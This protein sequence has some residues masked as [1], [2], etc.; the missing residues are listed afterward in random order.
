MATVLLK[1]GKESRVASGYLWI[2]S[3]EI[4]RADGHFEDGGIVDVRTLRGKWLGRGFINSQSGLA[5]RL[6]T[7]HP[8]A[9]DDAFWRRRLTGAL[10][11]RRRFVDHTTGYRLV[12][13]EGDLLPG[14]VVDRYAD[15]LVLQTLALGMEVRKEML[16]DLLMELVQPAAIYER[17]DASVRRLEGL[18]ARTGWLRG[19]AASRVEIAEGPAR[20]AVDIAGGQKTGF[21]LDQ[22]ENRLA[23]APYVRDAEVL[24]VFC[25]TGAFAIHAA[26][27]GA[28]RVTAVDSSAEAVHLAASNAGLNGVEDRCEF[29]EAN[30]FD[31]LRRLVGEKTAYDVVI[32][33]PPPF[34]PTRE[35]VERASAG[36]KEVNLRALRLLRPG[37]V[38][39][40][41]SCSYHVG[42]AL[43]LQIVAAAAADAHRDVRVIETRTQARDHPVHPAMPE[44]AYLSCVVLEVS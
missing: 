5:V 28:R 27:D 3:G 31:E 13:S 32:L 24:D 17:N 22:R 41:C 26:L 43:L 38:L 23:L 14:L 8:E 16:A 15:V 11:Y 18:E 9:I 34:A 44:T 7:T 36:Y 42:E 29:V 6:L 35:A 10:A 12:Y 40:T 37:G 21:Y 30:A 1:P 4:A 33:D 19:D 20:F 2:F 25:Y 39:V